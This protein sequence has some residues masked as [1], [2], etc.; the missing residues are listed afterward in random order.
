MSV[1]LESPGGPVRI[2]ILGPTPRVSDSVDFGWGL[3]IGISNKL[4]RD[5][6]LGNHLR[7]AGIMDSRAAFSLVAFL[8]VFKIRDLS[9]NKV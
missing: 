9:R 8:V 1:T 6:D 4:L 3:R 5:A 2:Q 7:I